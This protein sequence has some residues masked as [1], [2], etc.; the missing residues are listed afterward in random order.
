MTPRRPYLPGTSQVG[1]RVRFFSTCA[2]R[3]LC[4]S[5]WLLVRTTFFQTWG[6]SVEKQIVEVEVTSNTYEL[7]KALDQFV[8][9]VKQSLDDGWQTSQDVPALISAALAHLVPVLQNVSEVS[10]D[11]KDIQAFTNGLFLG[12]GQTAFRFVKKPE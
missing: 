1:A 10:E 4:R 8:G 6:F 9:A 12:L 5:Y 3:I 2:N 11:A 7:G